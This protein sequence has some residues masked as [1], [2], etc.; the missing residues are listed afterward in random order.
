KSK[1]DLF[2]NFWNFTWKNYSKFQDYES[3]VKNIKL[4]EYFQ[5]QKNFIKLNDLNYSNNYECSIS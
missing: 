4:F 3:A 5:D 2:F 1:I